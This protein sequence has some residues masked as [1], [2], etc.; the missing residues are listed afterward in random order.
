[1]AELDKVIKGLT[2]C[3]NSNNPY[4]HGCP[5]DNGDEKSVKCSLFLMKDAL[6]L[7]KEQK[8]KVEPISDGHTLNGHNERIGLI[9]FSNT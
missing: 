6:E 5:Y 2:E 1:M 3:T 9:D 8:E 4:C 7:L